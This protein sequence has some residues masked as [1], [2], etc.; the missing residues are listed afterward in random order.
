M[1]VSAAFDS[2]NIE[3][4]EITPE[5]VVVVRIRPD[6]PTATPEGEVRFAQWFHFRV[7]GSRGKRCTLR[8]LD[9]DK[10]AYPDGWPDYRVVA[11]HDQ[12]TW[13][14]VP[15]QFT[16]TELHVT[17]TPAAD[18]TW[19]AYFAPYPFTRHEALVGR[20]ASREGVRMQV[21]G[22][23]I[24]GRPLDCLRLGEQGPKIWVIARQHPGETMAE[25]WMEGF[26]DRLTDPHDALGRHLRANARWFVVPNMNPDG[27]VRGH[28]RTNASGANLNREWAEPSPTRS[29]EVL[30]VRDAMDASGVDLCLDVHG[31]EGLPYNFVSGAEGIPGW[32]ERMA[33]LQQRF[34]HAYERAN[35][36]FQCVQGYPLDPPGTANLTMCTN[37]IAQRFDCLAM[38]LEQPFKDNADAP[39][40]KFGWSPQRAVRLGASVLDAFVAVLQDLRSK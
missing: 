33:S 38:T 19:Y 36:D 15:T 12:E 37:H 20:I 39:D 23:S 5:R 7:S 17:H 9:A 16:G 22:T 10:A 34:L 32:T 24:E 8:F 14:R 2:G 18:V 25:W 11:S 6:P 28:L 30:H 4:V 1:R 40:P 35:P 3:L 21:L 27:S 31:D 13:F 29:P 26:L